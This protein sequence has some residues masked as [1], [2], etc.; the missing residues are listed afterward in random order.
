ML[1]VESDVQQRDG[2]AEKQNV[3]IENVM[4]P[5]KEKRVIKVTAKGWDMFLVN[6]QKTRNLK[7][8]HAKRIVEIVKELTQSNQNA[9]KMK[10]Y[11][12]ELNKLCDEANACQNSLEGLLP[13]I[14]IDKQE[15]WLKYKVD[16][17][18]AFAQD[19]EIWLN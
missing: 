14:E 8:R 5:V 16:K 17:L 2:D 3:A 1:D 6:T 9:N 11:L 15:Q 19:A 4:V 10:S 7:C 18:S 12:H 13:E